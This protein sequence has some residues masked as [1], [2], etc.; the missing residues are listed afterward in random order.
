[1][2][3]RVRRPRSVR[4]R[5]A[6]W[7]AGTLA[8]LLLVYASGVYVLLRQVEYRELD[9][10]LD[11]DFKVAEELLENATRT[12][13]ASP[14]GFRVAPPT[15]VDANPGSW[16]WLEIWSPEGRLLYANPEDLSVDRP[17]V[18]WAPPRTPY[19]PASVQAS[20]GVRVRVF[21]G[22]QTVLGT[23]VITRVVRSEQS[24]AQELYEFLLALVI[25]LP[26]VVG[27]AG[28]GGYVLAR[29]VLA[30]LGA[31]VERTRTITAERLGERLSVEKPSDEFGQLATVFN[32]M[33]TRLGDSFAQ[34]KRFT[35]DASHELRTPLTGIKSVG[36]VGLRGWRE[37]HEYREI[38]GSMLEESYRLECL[39][40]G[41]LNLAMSDSQETRLNLQRV[42]L[43]A[44]AR[45]VADCLSVLADE[46]KQT[47]VVNGADSAHV[48][49]DPLLLRQAL[50]NIL[51]NAVKYSP[52]LSTI[53]LTVEQT[54][55][56]ASVE[57]A[58][59]GPGIAPE[60]RRRIFDRFYRIDDARS[61]EHGGVGLG[62]SIAW[63]AVAAHEGR[64]EVCDREGWGSVFRIELP[65]I[66]HTRPTVGAVSLS[67][68]NQQMRGAQTI[69]SR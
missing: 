23:P 44:L 61:R 42:D 43:S 64:L 1:V 12:G 33:L 50:V 26:I 49:A 10:G 28:V 65:D 38:I 45:D 51:D 8:F 30:P 11:A 63:S 40:D 18:T 59:Q 25:G 62:L 69:T 58:D 16:R 5:L 4:V 22:P 19:G 31:I 2:T 15:P 27:L 36:E 37:A 34:L 57:L 24:L 32:D 55:T 35:W 48:T 53:R 54:A 41:L 67:A 66:A 47:I 7:Y 6:C 13:P 20:G 60:Y 29:R 3:L 9:R 14:L 39:V 52:E 56:C 21:S 17:R 46:K 68:A